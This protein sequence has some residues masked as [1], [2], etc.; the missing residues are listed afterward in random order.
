MG[1]PLHS[2]NNQNFKQPINFNPKDQTKGTYQ[3][4]AHLDIALSTLNVKPIVIDLTSPPTTYS[5]LLPN[6]SQ[7]RT[8]TTFQVNQ[9]NPVSTSQTSTNQKTTSNKRQRYNADTYDTDIHELTQ[10]QEVLPMPTA[11]TSNEKITLFFPWEKLL[12]P[13]PEWQQE[14]IVGHKFLTNS[15]L[16]DLFQLGLI[17]IPEFINIKTHKSGMPFEKIGE[18]FPLTFRSHFEKKDIDYFANPYPNYSIKF[19]WATLNQTEK[20]LVLASNHMR[21]ILANSLHDS[22]SPREC[23]K[24]EIGKISCD[25]LDKLFRSS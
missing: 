23:M 25:E 13:L 18:A 3:P 9:I 22:L 8:R 17:T 19:P 15:F 14:E 7:K 20:E 11:S 24:I 12:L 4:G 6:H 2:L 5:K 16:I 10:S 21:K 1:S